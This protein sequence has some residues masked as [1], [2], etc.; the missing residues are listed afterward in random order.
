MIS[1]FSVPSVGSWLTAYVFLGAV[2][3]PII[4]GIFCRHIFLV[5]CQ[6]TSRL[7]PNF[8]APKFFSK[9]LAIYLSFPKFALVIFRELYVY[10][11]PLQSQMTFSWLVYTVIFYD[12]F[13]S[14]T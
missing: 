14:C 10:F 7:P 12:Q 5:T 13:I 1:V 8:Q 3:H 6:T 4:S 9:L 2:S 11:L